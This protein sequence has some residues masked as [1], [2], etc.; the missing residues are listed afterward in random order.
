MKNSQ[1]LPQFI[2]KQSTG[3]LDLT[4]GLNVQ[5]YKFDSLGNCIT[6]TK[7]T[8][9]VEVGMG[10]GV[11]VNGTRVGEWQYYKKNGEVWFLASYDWDKII[12][13]NLLTGSYTFEYIIENYW[14]NYERYC[15][16]AG[17][18]YVTAAYT[19]TV[20]P[21]PTGDASVLLNFV[22]RRTS[23][24]AEQPFIAIEFTSSTYTSTN[25]SLR[26][27]FLF[28][29]KTNVTV[30]FNPRA[31][32]YTLSAVNN[33]Y[34]NM[35]VVSPDNRQYRYPFIPNQLTKY[36]VPNYGSILII[37]DSYNRGITIDL[38]EKL[39][40]LTANYVVKRLK[41]Q[42]LAGNTIYNYAVIIDGEYYYPENGYAVV[43]NLDNKQITVIPLNRTD[44]AFN[45]NVTT[46]GDITSVTAPFYVYTVQLV[47]KQQT[48]A[49]TEL[50]AAFNVNIIGQEY[51]DKQNLTNANYTFRVT[52]YDNY[53]VQLLPGNYQI[54]FGT[55]LFFPSMIIRTNT[56]NLS[57]FDNNYY[58]KIVWRVGLLSDSFNETI[59]T[60]P[61]LSVT[62]I[63]QYSKPVKNAQVEVIDSQNN[64]VGIKATDNNGNARFYVL[65]GADYT[66]KVYAAGNL[67]ATRTI[68][69]PAN[70]T[71]VQ[72]TVQISLTD[73]EQQAL[74]G[75]TGQPG[76]NAT[77]PGPQEAQNQ[78]SNI[79]AVIL[80][81]YA[82]W[83]FVFIIIFAAYAAKISGSSEIGILVAI[84]C[85]AVF[86][87]I[88]PWLP[89]QIIALIGVVAGVL[90]GLRLVRR[91]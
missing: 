46:S 72:L 66:V 91:S 49:G 3:S 78:I 10:G 5:Y 76:Q 19:L 1:L 89:V 90:F 36:I 9:N 33:Y 60:N 8:A 88:V 84:I 28:L 16:L 41:L 35:T 20:N 21:Q 4:R 77:V 54:N 85:I 29:K 65:S 69:F 48:I 7:Y 26:A 25:N 14:Q 50:P 2:Y 38:K 31:N 62:V 18:T 27:S 30:T 51:A 6:N 40:C 59:L 61:L 56:Y 81:N 68:S 43:P 47:V 80:T 44:L 12:N 74:S 17:Y 39:P 53:T 57:L 75:Q 71:V 70:E 11:Y 86:T 22:A 45:T 79:L 23:D 73:Q 52:A 83:A 67:K 82:I 32:T 63:D 13:L 42:D 15:Q 37:S 58:R 24:G 64:T 87:F 55:I 34:G